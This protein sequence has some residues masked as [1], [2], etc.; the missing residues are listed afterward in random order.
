VLKK[1]KRHSARDKFFFVRAPD[2]L[3]ED[4]SLC[5]WQFAC[6]YCAVQVDAG[7][8]A[9]TRPGRAPTGGPCL[10]RVQHQR[11]N[12]VVERQ[13]AA[14]ELVDA[15]H[16]GKVTSAPFDHCEVV[17]GLKHPHQQFRAHI[18][19][20]CGRVV[21]RMIKN[22][23]RIANAEKMLKISRFES[24]PCDAGTITTAS[25][26]ACCAQCAGRVVF[27]VVGDTQES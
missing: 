9:Q 24:S 20:A 10:Q 27:A 22:P 5:P 4:R 14:A 13:P 11:I 16:P 12:A 7:L 8:W 6:A 23:D 1:S 15:L 21:V 17:D 26:P 2:L 25:A 3:R 19:P 18:D